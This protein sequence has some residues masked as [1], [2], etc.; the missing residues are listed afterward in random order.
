M[1]LW[2]M[3]RQKLFLAMAV[4]LAVSLMVG[5]MAWEDSVLQLSCGY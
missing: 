1:K 2:T 3:V 4:L 5:A